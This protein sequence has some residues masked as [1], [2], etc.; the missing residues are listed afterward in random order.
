MFTKNFGIYEY[1]KDYRLFPIHTVS[2][3][4]RPF[5]LNTTSPNNQL[6]DR[7]HLVGTITIDGFI[8]IYLLNYPR[9]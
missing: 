4:D 2:K 9:N 1:A 6:C 3:E 5:A 7:P 8:A